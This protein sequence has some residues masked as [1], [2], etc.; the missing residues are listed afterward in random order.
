VEDDDGAMVTA[1]F[2]AAMAAGGH[3]NISIVLVRLRLA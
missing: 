2:E 3:D 1:L